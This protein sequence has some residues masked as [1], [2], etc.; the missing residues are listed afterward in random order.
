MERPYGYEEVDLY[1]YWLTLRRRWPTIGLVFVLALL[2]AAAAS[3]LMPRVYRV[4]AAIS[5]GRLGV[6]STGQVIRVVPP[7]DLVALIQ[8]GATGEPQP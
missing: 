7:E 1:E 5:P 6:S 3:A 8:E 4:T 2:A